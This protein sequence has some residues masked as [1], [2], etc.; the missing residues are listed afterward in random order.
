MVKNLSAKAGGIRDE[1][2]IPGSGRF[3]AGG[4]SNSLQYSCLGN[5][6]DRGAWR[7]TVHSVTQS[8]IRVKRLSML[9]H[10]HTHTHTHTRSQMWSLPPHSFQAGGESVIP[11]RLNFSRAGIQGASTSVRGD[12][13]WHVV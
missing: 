6:M 3:P 13:G 1:D 12:L 9:M 2:S 10:T 11:S 7:A 8:Q 4:H 5:P